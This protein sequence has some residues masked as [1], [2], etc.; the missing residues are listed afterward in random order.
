M[1]VYK[2][3]AGDGPKVEVASVS[4]GVEGRVRVAA[5]HTLSTRASNRATA[6]PQVSN[7]IVRAHGRIVVSWLDGPSVV[8]VATYDG[9][10]GEWTAPLPLGEGQD[11][12]AGAALTMDGEGFLYAAFG[13]HHGPFQFRRTLRPFDA[14]AWAPTEWFGA[15]CTHPSLVCAADDTLHLVHRVGRSRWR[16]HYRRRPR[17]GAWSEPLEL[18]DPCFGGYTHF[19]PSLAAGADG[20]LHLS[21]AVST[22]SPF[23]GRL[24]GYLRSTDG[25]RTWTDAA[26]DLVR[27]PLTPAGTGVLG[28]LETGDALQMTPSN[29]ALDSRGRP[30]LAVYHRERRPQDVTLWHHDGSAWRPRLISDEV[31]RAFPGYEHAAVATITFDAGGRLYLA[32]VLQ[33]EGEDHGAEKDGWGEPGDRVVLLTSDDGGGTFDVI[34]VSGVDPARPNWLATIERPYGSRPLDGPPGLVYTHGGSGVS[35]T[36]DR[37][38]AEVVFVHLTAGDAGSPLE[39]GAAR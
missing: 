4:A 31:R 23:A 21:F 10:S 34:A 29:L 13:P 30:W 7:K 18:V 20:S 16:L 8:Q 37:A 36:L 33:R 9:A 6:Y 38:S 14:T 28:V 3:S 1:L 35:N 22:G 5:T 17:G 12:H 32:A 15:D 27:L 26:G 25:G 2:P 11:N 24:V 19:W 39:R